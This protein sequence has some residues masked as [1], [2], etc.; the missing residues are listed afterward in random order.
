MEKLTDELLLLLELLDWA[1]II[2]FVLLSSTVKKAFGNIL[3]KITTFEWQP[4]YTVLAIATLL[5]IPWGIL[6]DSTWLE[7]LVSYSVGTTFY[8]VILKR[9]INKFEGSEKVD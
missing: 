9:I 2:I 7:I 4:V 3:Q 6:T 5:A 8:E 1:Y